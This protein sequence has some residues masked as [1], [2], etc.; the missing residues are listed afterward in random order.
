MT[1]IMR[2][3][4]ST[5]TENIAAIAGQ[6]SLILNP[7]VSVASIFEKTSDVSWLKTYFQLKINNEILK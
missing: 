1:Q 2:C 4:I 5:I 7:K 3:W 6:R